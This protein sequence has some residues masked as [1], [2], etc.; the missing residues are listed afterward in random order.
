MSF[1]AVLAL[2][3][4]GIVI[5]ILYSGYKNRFGGKNE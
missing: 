3:L 5:G 2:V 4:H 1:E